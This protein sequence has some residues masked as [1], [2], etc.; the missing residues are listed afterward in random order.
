MVCKLIISV[1]D[2]YLYHSFCFNSKNF[3]I[4]GFFIH[5]FNINSLSIY[6]DSGVY[7]S[8]YI[9]IQYIEGMRRRR[10]VDPSSIVPPLITNTTTAYSVSFAILSISTITTIQSTVTIN[11]RITT[12]TATKT[13]TGTQSTF[14]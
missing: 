2:E 6:L 13:T 8:H 1:I 11:I 12:I 4:F 10:L 7:I 3:F 14:N 9:T 5:K